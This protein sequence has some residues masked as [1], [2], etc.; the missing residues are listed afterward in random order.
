MD[1]ATAAR[2]GLVVLL[3]LVV[4]STFA[5][6]L[7]TGSAERTSYEAARSAVN[8]DLVDGVV[9]RLA[10]T[11]W[12]FVPLLAALA[13]LALVAG[14]PRL[15]AAG[16]VV[17]AVLVGAF[18]LVVAASPRHRAWGCPLGLGLSVALVPTAAL[19]AR[20]TRTGASRDR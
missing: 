13:A 1:G 8:L 16:A 11:V 12:P 14:L 19:A 7:R 4:A 15:A 5:P 2:T 18:A 6:W 9:A 3:A 17:V 10:R 20:P